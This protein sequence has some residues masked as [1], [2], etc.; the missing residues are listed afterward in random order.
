MENGIIVQESALNQ[1]YTVIHWSWTAHSPPLCRR[2]SGMNNP[3]SQNERQG[4]GWMVVVLAR[5]YYCHPS[6][7]D[8]NDN[9]NS[10]LIFPPTIWFSY[11]AEVSSSVS[12]SN[13]LLVALKLLPIFP[14]P[15]TSAAAGAAAASRFQPPGPKTINNKMSF[16]PSVV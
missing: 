6:E 4:P 9:C 5:H 8:A 2:R 14:C 15:P 7:E 3:I 13:G 12:P 10:S 1:M 11:P 16:P